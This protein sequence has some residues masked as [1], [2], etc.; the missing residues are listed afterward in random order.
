MPRKQVLVQLDDAL[1]A[2]LDRLAERL[3]LSRSELLRR[4]ALAVLEAERIDEAEREL[5]DA[6]LRWPQDPILV[7]A[8]RRLAAE[9]APPW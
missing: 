1:V 5:V 2:S 8:A 3:K 9:T 4:G 7:E 6:Y